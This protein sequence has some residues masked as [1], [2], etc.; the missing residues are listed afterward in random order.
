MLEKSFHPDQTLLESVVGCKPETVLKLGQ[1]LCFS[2]G[3]IH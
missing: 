1:A 3:N 2:N